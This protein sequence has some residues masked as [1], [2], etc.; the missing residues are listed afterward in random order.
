MTFINDNPRSTGSILGIHIGVNEAP[1]EF[2]W[3]QCDSQYKQPLIQEYFKGQDDV[4]W[5]RISSLGYHRYQMDH[6][7]S[8]YSTAKLFKNIYANRGTGV[9]SM[10]IP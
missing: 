5:Q 8:V 9:Y 2:V 7:S 1:P 4:K 10:R 6:V 3:M